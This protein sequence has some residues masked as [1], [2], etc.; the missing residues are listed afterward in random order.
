MKNLKLAFGVLAAFFAFLALLFA[1][2]LFGLGSFSFFA[3]KV[4]AVRRATFEQSKSYNDGMKRDLEN[5][6]MEYLAAD[7]THKAA[8][9]SIVIHR[10]SVY[11]EAEMSA[12]QRSF[13][14]EIR[15]AN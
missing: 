14:N 9:R 4:E 12:S 7:A 10:F 11:P 8:L 6:Q 1:L 3:P 13:Y 5:L 2:Q 15:S